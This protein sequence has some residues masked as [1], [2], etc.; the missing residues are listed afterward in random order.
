MTPW[1]IATVIVSPFAAR[2]AERHNPG[3]TAAV[4]MGVFSLGVVSLILL[5]WQGLASPLHIAMRMTLCG[6]GFGMFQTP[7]NIV[8]VRAV[9]MERSGGA[10]GMQGTARLVGQTGGATLVSLIFAAVATGTLAVE[11]CLLTALGF[12][13]A[14][15]GFS[16]SRSSL[17]K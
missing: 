5:C 3:I 2:W 7:N 15:G 17:V 4:G 16:L 8:M 11:T 13:L 9:P 12:A 1:P 14:A 6:V 10:G